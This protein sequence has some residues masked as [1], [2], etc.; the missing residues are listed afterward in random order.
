[1]LRFPKYGGKLNIWIKTNIKKLSAGFRH[2]TQ[3]VRLTRELRFT[4][5][6]RDRQRTVWN[7]NVLPSR[8]VIKLFSPL[9][10][11]LSLF[12][13][14]AKQQFF[15]LLHQPVNIAAFLS[16][17]RI[18]SADRDDPLF[19]RKMMHIT[20]LLIGWRVKDEM[21]RKRRMNTVLCDWLVT[22]VRKSAV[23][24]GKVNPPEFSV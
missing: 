11:A 1:M 4:N 9:G 3:L 21:N 12:P 13:S 23:I 5:R 8:P 14:E 18:P 20:A 2:F 10:N 17:V 22:K 24:V 7:Y 15:V 6:E 19:F 16:R